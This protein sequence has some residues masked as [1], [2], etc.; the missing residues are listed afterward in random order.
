[1]NQLLSY[2]NDM[3]FQVL[4]NE[5]KPLKKDKDEIALIGVENWG[6]GGFK[7]NGDF[8]KASFNVKESM[9]KI[10]L[11]HDPSHWQKKLLSI[12]LMLI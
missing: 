7:K 10:L 2:L 1:M 3:G 6:A 4:L 9:F 5:A 11:S 12:L 8:Q